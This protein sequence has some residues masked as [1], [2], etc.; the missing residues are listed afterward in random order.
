[1]PFASKK[2]RHEH[3]GKGFIGLKGFEILVNDEYLK[4]LP[5]ILETP[6]EGNMDIINIRILQ[7]LVHP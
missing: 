7:S 2:D 4:S 6:K 1:M 3:I 5:F